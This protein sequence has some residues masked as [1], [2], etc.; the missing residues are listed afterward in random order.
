VHG[1]Q[2]GAIGGEEEDEAAQKKAETEVWT[3]KVWAP[4]IPRSLSAP[5]QGIFTNDPS[6]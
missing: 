3:V 6:A 5:L 4:P 2:L 1:Q